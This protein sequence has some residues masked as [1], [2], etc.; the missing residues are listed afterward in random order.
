MEAVDNKLMHAMLERLWAHDKPDAI[1]IGLLGHADQAR[2]LGRWF[3]EREKR[4]PL[5]LDPV[6]KASAGKRLSGNDLY[7]A[8]RSELLPHATLIT[9]NHLEARSLSGKED[10]EQAIETL[11]TLGSQNVLLTGGDEAGDIITNTLHS[12]EGQKES[13]Q[14]RK[15]NSEFH[16]TGCTLASATA[17]YLA[18]GH[19]VRDA[20]HAG[21]RLTQKALAA[22]FIPT[23]GP[24]IPYRV[25]HND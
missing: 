6:L 12:A 14:H 15:I 19:N 5:V 18:Q 23:S 20:C 21:Q 1:K 4:P 8:I 16:G 13:W 17:C 22:A 25:S 7:E 11:L 10:I 2:M 24:A 9:P 3:Q